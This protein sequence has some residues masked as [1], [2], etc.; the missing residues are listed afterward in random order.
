MGSDSCYP[1][2]GTASHVH[3]TSPVDAVARPRSIGSYHDEERRAET[4]HFGTCL[5][6]H[7]TPLHT[8]INIVHFN[9]HVYCSSIAAESV[10]L[11]PYV[12]L[13]GR[14]RHRE[15]DFDEENTRSCGETSLQRI[16]VSL[17]IELLPRFM[18]RIW[19]DVV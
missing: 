13:H 11:A 5:T 16:A 12:R 18:Q 2:A 7:L 4:H 17:L 10:D 8:N 9:D 19:K 1:H 14:M 15:W 6:A 3:S